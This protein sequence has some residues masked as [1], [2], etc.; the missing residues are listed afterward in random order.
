MFPGI[1]NIGGSRS[2]AVG[3]KILEG[4]L[5]RSPLGRY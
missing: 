2:S 3:E 4:R 5:P 1:Y